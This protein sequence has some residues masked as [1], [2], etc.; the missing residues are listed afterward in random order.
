[1]PSSEGA[2]V[3]IANSYG[4]EPSR[5]F[6]VDMHSNVLS[7]K[8]WRTEWPQVRGGACC[9]REAPW[10]LHAKGLKVRA[11]SLDLCNQVNEKSASELREFVDHCGIETK[12]TLAVNVCKGRE[13]SL[14]AT[15]MK[16]F[17]KDE[18]FSDARLNALMFLCGFLNREDWLIR[19]L[20]EG[21]YV[22]NRQ[23]MVYAVIGL[24]RRSAIFDLF[25]AIAKAGRQHDFQT[26][27]SEYG[28]D[29]TL[30]GPD[31]SRFWAVKASLRGLKRR[32]LENA[33]KDRL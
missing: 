16:K 8:K 6:A 10:K 24:T 1:M 31:S 5:L 30:Y 21:S 2:E 28:T 25:K 12:M 14:V 13:D 33:L 32:S 22:L 29:E 9:V 20:S 26:F 3:P 7:G 19:P 4:I 18:P 27:F 17:V 15:L 11:A 23:P